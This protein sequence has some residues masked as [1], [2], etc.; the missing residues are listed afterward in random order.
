[1][2][3]L[4]LIISK[5]RGFKEKLTYSY[6]KLFNVVN[7]IADSGWHSLQKGGDIN[8]DLRGNELNVPIW[9]VSNSSYYCYWHNCCFVFE[10]KKITPSATVACS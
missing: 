10:P 7:S 5:S 3:F 1:M 8:G 2:Y 9:Y 4:N 6:D